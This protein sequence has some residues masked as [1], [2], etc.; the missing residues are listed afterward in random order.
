MTRFLTQAVEP[1]HKL[2]LHALGELPAGDTAEMEQFLADDPA[3]R[4]RLDTL[5]AQ[6]DSAVGAVAA[7]DAARPLSGATV[8]RAAARAAGAVAAWQDRPAVI[9]QIGPEPMTQGRVWKVARWP[10]SAAAALVVGLIVWTFASDPSAVGPE[11]AQNNRSGR[12]WRDQRGPWWMQDAPPSDR[13]PQVLRADGGDNGNSN[14]NSAADIPSR[15][16][17][18]SDADRAAGLFESPAAP[19]G[20]A[21]GDDLMAGLSVGD[22]YRGRLA[23]L[24]R[25]STDAW[26]ADDGW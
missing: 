26:A 15:P 11:T 14:S 3:A 23:A 6:F 9:G 21:A 19:R 22:G 16:D 17:G 8:S 20:P 2:L 24:H 4:R 12:S 25:V 5:H 13:L 10:L 1:D 7:V 18:V